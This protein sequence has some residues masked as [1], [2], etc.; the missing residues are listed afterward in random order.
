MGRPA[1]KIGCFGL[2]KISLIVFSKVTPFYSSEMGRPAIKIG[3]FGVKQFYFHSN[4]L[5]VEMMIVGEKPEI[6]ITAGTT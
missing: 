4:K 5:S 1:I 3:C 2:N 6:F